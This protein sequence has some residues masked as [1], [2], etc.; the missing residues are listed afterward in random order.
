MIWFRQVE[1]RYP[2]F[3]ETS[4]QRPGRWHGPGE[5]P[6]QYLSDTP[7]GA[8]AEFLRHEGITEEPDLATVERRMWA[9][10]VPELSEQ[11]SRPRL[12]QRMLRGGLET[13]SACQAEARRLRLRGATALAAPS[14]GLVLGGARGQLVRGKDLIEA[15]ARDGR[16]LA[17]LGPRPELRGWACMDA[18]RPAARVLGLVNQL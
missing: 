18:G 16:T 2:F 9:I 17:L 8:W 12:F 14:A 10:E 6:V 3:W 1:P 15:S 5:G 13:Y 11:I 4:W 7:D